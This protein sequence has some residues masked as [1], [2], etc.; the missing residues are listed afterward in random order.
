MKLNSHLFQASMERTFGTSGILRRES[1]DFR[2]RATPPRMSKRQ[3]L[4]LSS[5]SSWDLG[6]RLSVF[7]DN[8]ALK[9][10]EQHTRH[11]SV[12]HECFQ[13]RSGP[14]AICEPVWP[15]GKALGW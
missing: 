13:C 11:D 7:G 9:N 14:A 3:V 6:P 10:Q 12:H 2:V 15:S 8:L 1:F 4:P 5:T